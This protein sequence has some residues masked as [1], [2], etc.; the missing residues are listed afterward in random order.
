MKRFTLFVSAL[1]I[2]GGLLLAQVDKPSIE[3]YPDMPTPS[4]GSGGGPDCS[5]DR[6]YIC[7]LWCWEWF[8]IEMCIT[9]YCYWECR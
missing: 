1:C 6:A 9:K 3:Q 7:E 5:N 4:G 8:G 2:A